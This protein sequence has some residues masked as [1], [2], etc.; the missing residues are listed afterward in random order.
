MVSSEEDDV[1]EEQQE[2]P[3]VLLWAA[4][5]RTETRCRID[6]EA[7]APMGAQCTVRRSDFAPPRFLAVGNSK[8][9]AFATQLALFL[10]TGLAGCRRDI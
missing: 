9:V 8:P 2:R 3:V 10:W 6:G 7:K 5:R 1:G 4:V